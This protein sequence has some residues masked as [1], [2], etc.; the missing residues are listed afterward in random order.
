M[1]E[2][3]S[4][5]AEDPLEDLAMRHA[6]GTLSDAERAEFETCL[7]APD[8]RAAALAAEFRD[9][10]ATMTVATLSACPPPPAEVKTRI[11]D[12]IHKGDRP[13]L[14]TPAVSTTPH[15]STVLTAGDMAWTPT[16][17]RGVRIRELSSTS[18]DYVVV[19][20]SVDPGTS[21]PPHDHAG[22][23]DFYILTGDA[24]IDGRLLRAGDFMHSEPGTHHH[25]M[26]SQG[27]CQAI[28]ITS[29]KNYSPRLARA[30]G[31]AHRAVASVGR[32]LG[33]KVA[34]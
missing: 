28:L 24:S 21:F 32:A 34:D 10:V 30:Y 6:L 9:L 5:A 26:I 4:S 19:M 17:Y 11:F 22:A 27:G 1:N 16:P 20:V 14:A 12:A 7:S 18:P 8:G 3:Q 31:L 23:E 29:R 13:P 2:A 25:E 33:I 15:F